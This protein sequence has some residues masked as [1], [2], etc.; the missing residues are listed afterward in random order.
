MR[1]T[2]FGTLLTLSLLHSIKKRFSLR[3]AI[4][5]SMKTTKILCVCLTDPPITKP[6]YRFDYV[7]DDLTITGLYM[8]GFGNTS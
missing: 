4:A 2:E 8:K 5:Y 7:S 6:N 3:Y 1:L